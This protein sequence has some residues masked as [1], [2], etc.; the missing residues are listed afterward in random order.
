MAAVP[1]FQLHDPELLRRIMQRT[2]DGSSVSIRDLAEAAGVH[3]SHVGEILSG[4]QQT[5]R[6]DVAVA[7]AERVG[8]DLLVLWVPYGRTARAMAG[9]ARMQKVV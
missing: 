4:A 7:I 1:R 5:A 8:V 2:G 6:L 9:P 3:S